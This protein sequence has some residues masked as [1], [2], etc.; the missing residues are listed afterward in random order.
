MARQWG[1]APSDRFAGTADV[2]RIVRTDIHA[3]T[4]TPCFP[5]ATRIRGPTCPRLA[6]ASE[7]RVTRR[8]GAA[9]SDSGALRVGTGTQGRVE[10]QR[11]AVDADRHRSLRG[12]FEPRRGPRPRRRVS[13]WGAE[14]HDAEDALVQARPG[15]RARCRLQ[16]SA[17]PD[18]DVVD[19]DTAVHLGEIDDALAPVDEGVQCPDDVVS[20]DAKVVRASSARW[21]RAAL[22]LPE[23]GLK[24]RT[25]CRGREPGGAQCAP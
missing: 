5:A 15:T 9:R 20:V 23:R 3:H 22:P 12:D 7:P 13:I 21:Y 16:S 14:S 1:A 8:G 4:F 24:K 25:G 19:E 10:H 18:R 6:P 2:A 17:K 11:L